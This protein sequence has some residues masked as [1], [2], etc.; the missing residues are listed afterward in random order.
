MGGEQPGSDG[1]ATRNLR[2]YIRRIKRLRKKMGLP[3]L[4]YIAVTER[5]KRGGRYHHHITVN[6]G[7]DRDTLESMWEHGR[8]NSRR[9]QFDE[10]GVA[11]L[12]C[13]IVKSPIGG[14]A[15]TASKN[16][17]DPEPRKKDGRIS[18][19]KVRELAKSLESGEKF[20]KFECLY[21]GWLLSEAEAFHNDVTG[22]YYIEARFYKKD[23]KFI[24]PAQK[25]R[26]I[27]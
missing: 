12:A 9:L 19:R 4:K 13:Y 18:G 10:K 14:K 11:G 5:G 23:G 7:I 22:G 15:W 17:A 1:E 20:A 6:G 24:K 16:L 3:P 8:A 25:G 21:P 2:N 26:K 27:E